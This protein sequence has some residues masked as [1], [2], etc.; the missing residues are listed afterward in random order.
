M[1]TMSHLRLIRSTQ[2]VLEADGDL[3][4]ATGILAVRN[5]K[6]IAIG[7]VRRDV[8][9]AAGR[10]VFVVAVDETHVLWQVPSKLHK[11]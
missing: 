5:E 1:H 10:V 11:F 9:V 6:E 4:R 8:V 7:G 3:Q 2:V